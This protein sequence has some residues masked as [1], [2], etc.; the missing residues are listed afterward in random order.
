M[1]LE[2]KGTSGAICIMSAVWATLGT[3]LTGS[4]GETGRTRQGRELGSLEY[5]VRCG[6][7]RAPVVSAL[8]S[9]VIPVL[10]GTASVS[11]CVAMNSFF[12][13]LAVR[14]VGVGGFPGNK[15]IKTYDSFLSFAPQL[16]L[17][18]EEF[19]PLPLDQLRNIF[20]DIDVAEFL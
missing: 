12:N 18:V 7:K 2:F 15:F 5:E 4:V 1:L 16:S 6:S 13:S 19:L 9:V 10:W 3:A 17:N 8:V 11:A 20:I 14:I